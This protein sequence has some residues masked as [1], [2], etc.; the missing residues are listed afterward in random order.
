[1]LATGAMSVDEIEI[2]PLVERRVHRVRQAGKQERVAVAGCPHD[3]FGAD[4]AAGAR[5][6]LDHDGLPQ[7]L[8]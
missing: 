3:G 1:M 6:V 5:S 8:R 7:P 4:I 2:E